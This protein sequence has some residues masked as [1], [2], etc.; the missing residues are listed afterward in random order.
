[1]KKLRTFDLLSVYNKRKHCE[2][3]LQSSGYDP[4]RL[5][6]TADPEYGHSQLDGS[7][8][9]DAQAYDAQINAL[10]DDGGMPPSFG[11]PPSSS[12]ATSASLSGGFSFP[13]SA[14]PPSAKAMPRTSTSA[15][16]PCPAEARRTGKQDEE[17]SGCLS[18]DAYAFQQLVSFV[19]TDFTA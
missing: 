11:A 10:I 3:A 19:S 2:S 12:G 5:P 15:T 4:K 14:A 9:A 16:R 13:C 18:N 6:R 1:M 7:G 17:T 8:E